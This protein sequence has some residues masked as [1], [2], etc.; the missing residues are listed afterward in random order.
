MAFC[1][2]CGAEVSGAAF[3]PKCGASQTAGVAA[4]ASVQVS[5]DG[6]AEN[7]AGLLCYVLG[8]V[9]GLFSC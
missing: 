6:L 9:T 3:C 4:P 7:V 2:A 5:S 8:W 1:Q